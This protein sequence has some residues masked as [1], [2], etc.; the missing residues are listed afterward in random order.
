MAFKYPKL[1]SETHYNRSLS[2]DLLLFVFIPNDSNLELSINELV[3]LRSQHQ[4]NPNH[5]ELSWENFTLMML[6]PCTFD[7]ILNL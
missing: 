4:R 7:I 2:D 1:E 6:N 5:E 3:K